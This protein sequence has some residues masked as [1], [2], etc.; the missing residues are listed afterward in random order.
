MSDVT[1]FEVALPF[2]TWNGAYTSS[3]NG[4]IY[5]T[6]KYKKWLKQAGWEYI[7]QRNQWM[8]AN[9]PVLT[10]NCA[11]SVSLWVTDKVRSGVIANE[12]HAR[13][14]DNHVKMTYDFLEEMGILK[15]DKLVA[16]GHQYWSSEILGMKIRIEPV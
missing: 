11:V 1:E 10:Y 6:D 9:Q 15:N 13:D 8:R 5:R 3:K 16:E 14:L 2:C 12:S 4:Q 7:N